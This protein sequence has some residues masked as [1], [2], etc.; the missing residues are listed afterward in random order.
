MNYL[1]REERR[2]MILS[3]AK[4]AALQ[5]GLSGLTVRRVAAEAQVST[6]QVHHHFQSSSHLKAEVFVELMDQ[7]NEIEDGIETS[8]QMVRIRLILGYEDTEQTQAYLRLWNEA[9]VLMQQDE[10]IRLAYQL[11][12]QHWHAALIKEIQT[13]VMLKQFKDLTMPQIHE[14]AWRLIAFVCGLD[15]IFKIGLQGFEESSF[16]HHVQIM[17]DYELLASKH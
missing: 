6:G 7:L 4:Q 11:T 8:N 17:L 13:G 14:V 16:K 3:A 12:M 10:Q 5:D 9:E 1:N 15:G 2:A